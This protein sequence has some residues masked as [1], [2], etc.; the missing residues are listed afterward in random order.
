MAESLWDHKPW[1]CQPW[2]ILLSGLGAV[3]ASWL[4][5]GRWWLT[6]LEGL[7]VGGWWLVFLVLVPIA[8]RR[9]LEPPEG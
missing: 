3:A 2:S 5:G 9:S 1:W 4:L 6:L 7:G 8:Y